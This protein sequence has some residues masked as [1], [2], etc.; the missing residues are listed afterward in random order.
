MMEADGAI[1]KV[2]TP[3]ANPDPCK[4][5][6]LAPRSH[7]VG[8]FADLATRPCVGASAGLSVAECHAWQEFHDGLQ[9]PVRGDAPDCRQNRD[10]PCDCGNSTC[11]R[12]TS[13]CVECRNGTEGAFS[14]VKVN[15][16]A[17]L[18]GGTIASSVGGLTDLEYLVLD[19]NQLSGSIPPEVGA[20]SKLSVLWASGNSLTGA[21]PNLP[22]SRFSHLL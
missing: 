15:L 22:Y 13:P 4:V 12:E 16:A 2:L 20:L 1:D 6:A 10:A 9:W 11:P 3:A 18:A 19:S 21:L 7:S 17:S 14:I 8:S 5:A